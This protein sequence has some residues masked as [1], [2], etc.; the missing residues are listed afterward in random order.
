MAALELGAALRTCTD[1]ASVNESFICVLTIWTMIEKN[2]CEPDQQA[3]T[4]MI[5]KVRSHQPDIDSQKAE[6]Q[7]SFSRRDPSGRQ[8]EQTVFH[9]RN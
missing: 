8:L 7:A 5:E 6:S 4:A 2:R 3:Y 1:R 9:Q